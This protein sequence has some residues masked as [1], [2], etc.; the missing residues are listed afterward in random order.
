ML[1]IYNNLYIIDVSWK[2]SND[3]PRTDFVDLFFFGVIFCSSMAEG[4]KLGL[5]QCGTRQL[6]EKLTKVVPKGLN[7]FGFCGLTAV[8]SIIASLI[9]SW[10]W[11]EC[12]L[13]SRTSSSMI[14][15]QLRSTEIE[16]H[17]PCS[18]SNVSWRFLGANFFFF[19]N[20]PKNESKEW[21]IFKGRIWVCLIY[22]CQKKRLMR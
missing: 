3:E 13:L 14:L 17:L 2:W 18:C 4:S 22:A 15:Q 6:R 5:Q 8:E 10:M 19:L 20:P 21:T 7:S 9:Y 16:I 11:V 12:H 1:H